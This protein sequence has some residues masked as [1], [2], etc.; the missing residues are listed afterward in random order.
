MLQAPTFH[1]QSAPR[2]RLRAGR[3]K[4]CSAQQQQI[5][6]SPHSHALPASLAWASH[7]ALDPSMAP[8]QSEAHRNE[9]PAGYGSPASTI[10]AEQYFAPSSFQPI[11]DREQ[12]SPSF[13]LNAAARGQMAEPHDAWQ[14]PSSGVAPGSTAIRHAHAP[15]AKGAS[16]LD[17]RMR[18][19][20]SSANEPGP[21]SP[22]SSGL[23]PASMHGSL[24]H[25]NGA[26]LASD[27]TSACRPWDSA[28]PGSPCIPGTA[29]ALLQR[30]HLRKSCCH[31]WVLWLLL[32]RA[33][34]VGAVLL[35]SQPIVDSAV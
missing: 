4:R 15:L 14:Q 12:H 32:H 8:L 3:R 33:D 20:L 27:S 7:G 35:T 25:G 30:Y 34:N 10:P 28:D 6:P 21:G 26:G 29:S 11:R 16:P 17:V 22:S 24:W 23:H 31:V 9:D 13:V 18:L 19:D 5:S 2:S 1:P